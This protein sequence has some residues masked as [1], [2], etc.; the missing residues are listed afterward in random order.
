MDIIDQADELQQQFFERNL[1][2]IRRE[3]ET[4]GS[5]ECIDCGEEIPEARREKMPNAIRCVSC[6]DIYDRKKIRR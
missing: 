3:L 6:Q 2:K 5:E 1:G 4:E